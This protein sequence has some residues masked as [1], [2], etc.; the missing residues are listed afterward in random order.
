M[1]SLPIVRFAVLT[2]VAVGTPSVSAAAPCDIEGTIVDATGRPVAGIDVAVAEGAASRHTTTDQTG[3]FRFATVADSR[4]VIV[5]LRDG[6]AADHRF[7]ITAA[8][9]PSQL[10]APV[11]V[12]ATC[13][14]SLGPDYPNHTDADLLALY[15]G[16][17][18]G[19]SLMAQLGIKPGPPLVVDSA[20][21]IANDDAAYWVGPSSFNPDD[22]QPMRI[23]LGRAAA[24]RDDSGAPDNREHHELGHHALAMALG[25]LPRSRDALEGGYHRDPSSTAAWTEGFAIF[26]AAMVAT[27]VQQR[28]DAG[29]YRVQGAWID[30]ELDYQP[31]DLRGRESVAVA[32]LLWDMVDG[33]RTAVDSALVVQDLELLTDAGVPHL[34]VGRVHNPSA[35]P[36]SEG[37][38]HIDAGGFS[39]VAPVVPATVAPD[40]HG[41]FGLP[42]PATVAEA[43]DPLAA[44]KATATLR[45]AAEDDDPVQVELSA[46]WTAIIE[47]RSEQPQSNGRLFD[48]ADLYQALRGRF[49]KDADGDGR[50]DID[51]L[52]AAHGLFADLDG[53]RTYDEGETLGLTSHPGRTITVDG[54]E[55]SW[56]DLIP[57]HR[58]T[59]PPA[60]QVTSQTQ[61]SEAMLAIVVPSSPWGG[62]ATT[63]DDQGRFW[64]VAPPAIAD[65]SISVIAFA[66]NR[67]PTVVLH[68]DAL[69]L[70]PEL[71][72]HEAGY[73]SA[74]GTLPRAMTGVAGVAALASWPRVAFLGGTLA[75]LLG[76]VLMVI[77]RPR[78]R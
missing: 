50:D 26:F 76:L 77:G 46:L 41:W 53:D 71:E 11:S 69:T 45:P 56:P 44:I 15:Q 78:A 10:R 4:E 25:A 23:V 67:R 8:G 70:L 1:I 31:W 75:V 18:E 43:S 21:P 7:S 58:L 27:E 9:T 37:R 54:T 63:A 68:R 57:R 73:L 38:V 28:V 22:D 29:H 51:Q 72:Q 42:V 66:P 36:I 48:V 59:L 35:A 55:Q 60:L 34:L 17:H 12:D 52:F 16:L 14:V 6:L 74:S 32:S 5:T 33:P 30:L 39:G 2:V 3:R 47:L 24:R 64:M 62:H 49:G 13:T 61:P 19:F 65:T 20:D 40:A